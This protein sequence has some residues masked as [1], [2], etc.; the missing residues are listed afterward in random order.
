MKK[1]LEKKGL[2][3]CNKGDQ[4]YLAFKISSHLESLL[5]FNDWKT[6]MKKL[7]Y[8]Y[9]THEMFYRLLKCTTLKEDK[10]LEKTTMELLQVSKE[11]YK[12]IGRKKTSK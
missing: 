11:S 8:N 10:V 12:K 2:G 5:Q 7:Q 6:M 9:K 4:V 1:V 3:L